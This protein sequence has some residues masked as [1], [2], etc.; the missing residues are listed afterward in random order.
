MEASFDRDCNPNQYETRPKADIREV[1]GAGGR[2]SVPSY[3]A[4]PGRVYDRRERAPRKYSMVSP[5]PAKSDVRDPSMPRTMLGDRACVYVR[6]ST[7]EQEEGH[8]IDGQIHD[9]RAYADAHNYRVVRQFVDVESGRTDNRDGFIRV[10]E[11]ASRGLLDVVVVWKPDRIGRSTENNQVFRR[12]LRSKGVRVESVSTGPQDD[13]PYS[14][15]QDTIWDAIAEL[16]GH[17]IAHRM[18]LGRD[19]A[20]RKGLWPTKYPFGYR[21]NP[22]TGLLEVHEREAATMRF[23]YAECIRGASRQRLAEVMDVSPTSVSNRLRNP[24]YKGEYSYNGCPIRV[25]PVVSVETWEA[26]QAALDS[27]HPWNP[28]RVHYGMGLKAPYDATKTIVEE[29]LTRPTGGEPG[30]QT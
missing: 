12:M 22:E 14:R 26:A 30:R 3:T 19:S 1:V 20:A 24:L 28:K 8:S 11:C 9:C 25:P 13:N 23:A 5:P 27:R 16:D 7:P 4:I 2:R 10:L 17:V 21:R 18:Q 29:E 15:F 6:V